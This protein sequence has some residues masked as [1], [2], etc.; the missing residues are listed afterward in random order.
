MMWPS[1]SSGRPA[2]ALI[3]TGRSVAVRSRAAIV[4]VSVDAAAAIRAYDIGAGCGEPAA[5]CSGVAPVMVRSLLRPVSN[6][7][8][9]DDGQAGFGTRRLDGD[10]RFLEIAHGFDD[11]SPRRPP[12]ASAAGLLFEGGAQIALPETSPAASILPLGPMEA[13]TRGAA[14]DALAGESDAGRD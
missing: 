9:G 6:D 3:Q 14:G 2:L 7:H 12:S 4:D 1:T 10:G 5:A 8:A 11:A 13:K